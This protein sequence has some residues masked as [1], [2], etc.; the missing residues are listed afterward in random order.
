MNSGSM[1]IPNYLGNKTLLTIINNEA[2]ADNE[3]ALFDAKN[4]LLRQKRNPS[5]RSGNV[6]F[7][8]H[9]IRLSSITPPDKTSVRMEGQ[10]F[11]RQEMKSNESLGD[12]TKGNS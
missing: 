10:P 5:V 9:W 7:L 11:M 3:N 12:S 1:L 6:I 8:T 2:T 4:E